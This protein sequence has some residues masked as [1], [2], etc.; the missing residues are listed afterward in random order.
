MGNKK[1]L[2]KIRRSSMSFLK[3]VLKILREFTKLATTHLLM[4]ICIAIPPLVF[5]HLFTSWGMSQGVAWLMAIPATIILFIS[6]FAFLAIVGSM[7]NKL[8]ELPKSDE[9][10]S[11]V[12][13][14]Y[15]IATILA[16]LSAP[17]WNE[18]QDWLHDVLLARRQLLDS[19]SPKWKVTLITHW[20]LSTFCLVVIVDRIKQVASGILKLR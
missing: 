10:K 9:Q 8:Y 5:V 20:R 17:E 18:Y 16:D 7:I 15:W 2:R 13:F 12:K 11:N 4:E 6:I 14:A 1:L 3:G 19:K